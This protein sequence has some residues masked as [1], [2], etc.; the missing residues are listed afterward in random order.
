MNPIT[1]SM[2]LMLAGI[3]VEKCGLLVI[4]TTLKS[5]LKL[6]SKYDEPNNN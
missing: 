3:I 1:L 6:M 4:E 2:V 5:L